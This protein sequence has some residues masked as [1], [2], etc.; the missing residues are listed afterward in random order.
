MST[1][2][3][4]SGKGSPLT[5]DEVDS[6]FTN[7]NTDKYESGDSPSF[8]NIT[9]TGT[10]D[11]RDIATD[12]TKLDGIEA[13]ADVTDA[14]NVTAAGAL[15]DSELTSEASVKALNQGVATT[16]SP[17]FAG[18]TTTA[19][20]NF[21]DNDKA[22]FGA[23]S[24]LQIYHNGSTSFI[25]DAG[26]GALAIRSNEIQLQKYTGE[27]LASFLADST[28]QLRYDNS[29][30]LA[31]T[32]TGIDVTGTTTTDLLA[33]GN[34]AIT[35]SLQVTGQ[36]YGT[37]VTAA[38]GATITPN[39]ANGNMFSVTIAGNRTL[40][41]PTNG[42]PGQVGS[43]FVKQDG[44]GSRTLSFGS[45]WHFPAASAPTLTTTG[46]AVDRIDYVVYAANAVHAIATLDNR[47]S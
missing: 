44:T 6:N 41:N 15:M 1:I 16:D 14:T 38:D 12:G 21:G 28:V 17:S 4:R 2:T 18:L 11:G 3:T 33:T 32:S 34:T 29:V 26:T 22:I 35:G 8:V 37:V 23:G 39:F 5:H 7:L 19:N 25:D 24:D 31:T 43:I 13:N 40:A 9:V 36:A 10:V 42:Q 27:T 30:K 20:L 46:N 47:N 45:N